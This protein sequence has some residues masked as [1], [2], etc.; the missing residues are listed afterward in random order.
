MLICRG[1]PFIVGLN[2]YLESLP[3]RYEEGMRIKMNVDGEDDWAY[4]SKTSF[5][6]GTI[7]EVGDSSPQWPGS[8][9][10]S[11]KVPLSILKLGLV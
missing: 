7:V 9:W 5:F 8:Q 1:S 2:K 10:R 6:T 3:H 4:A 11:L